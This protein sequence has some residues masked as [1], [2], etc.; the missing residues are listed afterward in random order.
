MNRTLGGDAE[1][2]ASLS[3]VAGVEGGDHVGKSVDGGFNHH[4]IVA[5]GPGGTSAVIE[6]HRHAHARKFIQ[7]QAHIALAD[8]GNCQMF[9]SDQD[10]FVLQHQRHGQQQGAMPIQYVQKQLSGCAAGS[11]APRCRSA[12]RVQIISYDNENNFYS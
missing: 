11:S 5:V 6:C 7:Y 1:F 2:L 9:R 12:N 4:F 8:A 10:I 3:H